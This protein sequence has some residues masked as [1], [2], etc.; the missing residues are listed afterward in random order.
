MDRY[1]LDLSLKK[2]EALRALTDAPDWFQSIIDR[3]ATKKDDV[4]KGNV[5]WTHC[6]CHV[7]RLEVTKRNAVTFELFKYDD[8][9]MS[10]DLS[11]KKKQCLRCAVEC[12]F[13]IY[14]RTKK[15]VFVVYDSIYEKTNVGYVLN[16][17][18]SCQIR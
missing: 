13:F 15:W 7:E 9:K 8:K 17:Y 3:A 6:F 16:L 10:T 14:N 4:E 2:V 1:A 5:I 18:I 12:L 11:P